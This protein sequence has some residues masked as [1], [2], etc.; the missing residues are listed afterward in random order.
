MESSTTTRRLSL[1]GSTK[2]INSESS[3][4]NRELTYIPSLLDSPRL[5]LR[6]KRL[7][8][9]LT[10]I[11]LVTSPR[12][13]ATLELHSERLCILPFPN[14]EYRCRSSKKLRTNITSRS[15]V[16]TASTLNQ[17]TTSTTFQTSADLVAPK[18]ISSKTCTMVS[19]P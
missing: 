15:E 6:L 7:L 5:S 13:Q 19:R 12:A 4:C 11:I 17:P 14:L 1:S 9:L 18:L 3:Q 8:N 2:R 16:S 10:T